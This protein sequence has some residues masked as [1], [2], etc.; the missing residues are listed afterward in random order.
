MSAAA[1]LVVWMGFCL[2]P[3]HAYQEAPILAA[4]VQ[5]GEL[6]PVDER[7]PETPVVV[8]PVESIGVYGGTW[9]RLARSA[10]DMGLNSRLGYE[11]LVRWD[12]TG[13]RVVAGIAESWEV[14]EDA[15]EFTFHL[16]RGMRWSDGAPFTSADFLFTHRDMELNRE[17]QPSHTPWKVIND[18]VM[19]VEAPDDYTIVIRFSESYG[20]FLEMLCYRGQMGGLCMP[21][22]YLS[23]FHASYRDPDELNAEAREAG[24]LDWKAYYRD[25]T[26][27]E[28][29]P[30]L[31]TINA[32]VCKVPF[33]A[34]RALAVRNPYYW[35]VDPA[36]NQLP[37][38][39]QIAYTTVF[40]GNVLNMKAQSGEVDFQTRQINAGNFTS[41]ME[42]RDRARD[43]ANRYRVHVEPAT[44]A[45]AVY[46]NQHSRDDALRPL[47]QD[48]R[49]RLAL[50]AAIDREEIVEMVFSGLAEPS[51][52]VTTEVDW[53]YTPG[54]DKR[55]TA[56]DPA[57]ANRLLDELGMTR[58]AD[59]MRRMPDG[60]TFREILH[61]F[62]AESGNTEDLWL[63]VSEYWREVGLSFVVK[64]EDGTLS[65]MQVRNGDSDFWAYASAG[66]H[67]ELDGLWLA[68]I[69]A[70][71]YY[72]PL[73]GRYHV[74]EGRAGVQP[75]PEHQRLVDWYHEMKSTP[76]LQ[77]RLEVGRQVLEQWS[78]MC[79]LIGICRKP[80]VFII[81]NRFRNVP[82]KIIQD[83]RLMSPGY[84]GIEQFWL[85]REAQ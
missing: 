31:P 54:I 40:D 19:E 33:P 51:N 18:E 50:S 42:S 79:Y 53:Y 4:R 17:L 32:F 27:R 69:S 37:Y 63:L 12:R 8:E 21:R 6:P 66:V 2:C 44:G 28:E 38:I 72:A 49:F 84:I 67:W 16:R 24:F 65:G 25:L 34:P 36:G 7:L 77:H 70:S 82:E 41:F 60:S 15:T 56:Y 22:H 5:A 43:P 39:D 73:Y 14:N 10:G 20:L 83:Y 75:P 62:P 3:A 26:N 52:G 55:N 61:V 57:L 71:S 46:V 74:S 59:G 13:T 9:R 35:K 85:D 11:T 68:P 76:D 48:R 58:G 81:S 1:A 80:E 29:N 30:D 64:H 23:R 45:I 47:L 78:D